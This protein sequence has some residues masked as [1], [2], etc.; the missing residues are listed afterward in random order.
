[1][2]I[3]AFP[4]YVWLEIFEFCEHGALRCRE[5]C[6]A[7]TQLYREHGARIYTA[8]LARLWLDTARSDA[9]TPLQRL[10]AVVC[11]RMRNGAPRDPHTTGRSLTQLQARSCLGK[12]CGGGAALTGYRFPPTM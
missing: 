8:M 12:H 2:W 9:H 6:K 3:G 1:M 11:F 7:M 5:T 10:R 4:L